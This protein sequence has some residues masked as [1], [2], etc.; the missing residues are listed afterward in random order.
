MREPDAVGESAQLRDAVRSQRRDAHGVLASE[1][2][3][4]AE[5]LLLDC[6]QIDH[7]E[8]IAGTG[9]PS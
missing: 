6:V 9:Q 5:H 8:T 3:P 4:A 1:R 2:L 7:A